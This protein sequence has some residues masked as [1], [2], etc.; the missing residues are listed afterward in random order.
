MYVP[1]VKQGM[2][3][4]P[5]NFGIELAGLTFDEIFEKHPKWV[6]CVSEMWTDKCT[7]LFKRF[8]KYILLRLKDDL[9]RIEH[10]QRCHKYVNSLTNRN[11]PEYLL[12]YVARCTPP[13][14]I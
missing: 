6:A 3:R 4:F 10:E 11:I 7:G 5:D 1:I 2:D 12:K 14:G 13:T 8:R 9:S